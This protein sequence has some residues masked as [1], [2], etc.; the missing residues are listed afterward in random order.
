MEGKKGA[1]EPS[2]PCPFEYKSTLQ[3]HCQFFDPDGDGIVWPQNTFFGFRQLGFN[4][5]MCFLS[6]L[7]IHATLSYPTVPNAILP[8]PFARIFMERVHRDKHG[9]DSGCYDN[10]G[11]FLEVKF[12]KYFERYSSRP[13]KDGLTVWD[14]VRA[15]WGQRCSMDF[16]GISS[17][18]IEWMTTWMMFMP[19][20]GVLKKED[21]RKVF[22]GSM[23]WKVAGKRGVK[24]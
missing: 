22:D 19:A 24:M 13:E 11:E 8:D 18:V 4:W 6:M 15:I 9:S 12:D 2:R 17:N 21:V 10:D 7:I 1:G 23:F 5:L 3:N 20:D 14:T 16:Y